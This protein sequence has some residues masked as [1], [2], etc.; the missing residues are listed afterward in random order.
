[1]KWDTREP[2]G[3]CPYRRDAKLGLWHPDEFDNLVSTE[4]SQM[5]SLFGCHATRKLADPSV[6]AGWLI[7]QRENGVPSIVLRLNLMRSQEAV[8]CM[9]AVSSGGH[10]LYDSVDEMVEANEALGR[11]DAC[12]CYL[13]EDGDCPGCERL[14]PRRSRAAR[15]RKKAKAR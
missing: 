11:C 9:E 5:G 12:G 3:S 1:M 14:R 8:D 13:G 4:R 6:C 10:E 2:C 7:M 15:A